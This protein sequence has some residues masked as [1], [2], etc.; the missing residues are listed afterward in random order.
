MAR[1]AYVNG[2]Y[3]PLRN[4]AVAAG[5]SRL[6]V[7]RRRL[8]GDQGAGRAAARPRAPSRPAGALARRSRDRAADDAPRRWRACCSRRCGGTGSPTR[9]S[10]SRSRAAPRRAIICSPSGPARRWWS[11]CAGR[12]FPAQRERE[13]GVGVITRP[14][15]RWG[16]CDIKS[17]SLL[18]NVMARQSAAAAG[19]REAWLIDQR[20]HG[21]RGVGVQRLHRRRGGAA[22]HASARASASSAA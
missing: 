3:R 7:R 2:R 4:A 1:I 14:D 10:I 9:S 16:R 11:P 22:R 17:I 15:L 18:P 6:P 13:E 5:G 19:C 8:R 20:G 21:D 12:S